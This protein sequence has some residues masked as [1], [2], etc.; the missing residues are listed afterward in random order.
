MP[1]VDCHVQ[2]AGPAENGVVYIA[3]SANDGSFSPRWFQAN[4]TMKREMLATALSAMNADQTV[5]T[6]LTGTAQY[7]EINRPS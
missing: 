5:V 7:S 3:L 2:R 4:P 1:W 6:F